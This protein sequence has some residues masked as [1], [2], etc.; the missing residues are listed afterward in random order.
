MRKYLKR[1]ALLLKDRRGNML[2]LVVAVTIY[3]HLSDQRGRCHFMT[4]K[5]SNA[6][7]KVLEKVAS[8]SV[9]MA[10]DSRCMYIYHQPKQPAGVKEFRNK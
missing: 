1:A 5:A 2:P 9:K 7:A 8:K 6:V 4:K 3:L 10:A